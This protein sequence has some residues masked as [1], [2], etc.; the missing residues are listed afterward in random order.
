VLHLLPAL[1]LSNVM[2][3]SSSVTVVSYNLYWWNV[4]QNNRWSSLYSTLG[5]NKADLYGFQECEN[6]DQVMSGA[7]LSGYSTWQGPNKPAGNPAP[8]AWKSSQF[9]VISGPDS[10]RVASDR[11]GTRYL[12]WVRLQEKSSGKT[13]F[14]GNT[15]GPLGQC[16]SS[17]LAANWG[18]A[19]TNNMESNDVVI[20]TGD[21]NCGFGDSA[22]SQVR[23]ILP[24]HGVKHGI[25]MILTSV[26]ASGGVYDGQPSDHP[27]IKADVNV[28][29]GSGGSG[30]GGGTV[31]SGG[32]NCPST[33]ACNGDDCYTCKARAE[34]VHGNLGVSQEEADRRIK[35][36]FPNECAACVSGGG[37]GGSSPTCFD[38]QS[39][40]N[41]W[42]QHG[43]CHG[44]HAESMEYWCP[45]SCGLCVSAFELPPGSSS[46]KSIESASAINKDTDD[47]L[48][49]GSV[50]IFALRSSLVLSVAASVLVTIV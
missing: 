42:Q 46:P 31:G 2:H 6:V 9:S 10:V 4:R 3:L 27:L 1:M 30:N 11:W 15:H 28:G 38:L 43:F 12:T 14:F 29:G 44:E 45:Q 8:L 5:T 35:A 7:S 25:D 36:E 37:S 39:D 33:V 22:L 41:S 40:C 47:S 23:G 17:T 19:I 21:W 16:G 13:I 49:S 50:R 18:N 32:T 26:P 20:V 24:S 34:W 48:V